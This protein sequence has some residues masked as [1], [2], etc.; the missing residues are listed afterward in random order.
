MKKIRILFIALCF[1][2]GLFAQPMHNMHSA[3]AENPDMAYYAAE[4]LSLYIQ[5]ESVSGNE[6]NAGI[7][8]SELATQMGLHLKIFTCETNS[9][10]FAASLYPLEEGKPNVVFIS[11]VDVV[12]PGE[13]SL[14]TY[15]PFG[16]VIADGFVWGRGAIDCKSLGIMQLIAIAHFV[17]FAVENDLPY[18]FTLLAVSN[19]ELGGKLGARIIAEHFLDELNPVAV[20]GEGGAGIKGI[21][22]ANPD[23][24]YFGIEVEQ[25]TNLWFR[26]MASNAVSGHGSIPP[27][28]YPAKQIAHITSSL[29]GSKQPIKITPSGRQM[30][31]KLAEHEKGFLKFALR[32]MNFC[33]IFFP[34]K[35]RQDP[36]I[37]ALLTNTITVT[38]LESSKTASNQIAHSSVATFDCRLLPGVTPEKFLKANRKHFGDLYH[39]I[40]IIDISPMSTTSEAGY[41]YV[42]LSNAIQNVYEG[43]LTGPMLF[44]AINDNAY[45][46]EKGIPTYGL[47]PFILTQEL[48]ESIHYFDERIE[49]ESLERGT[50]VYK[51]LIRN[52]LYGI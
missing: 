20:Y 33:K 35:I 50:D 40:E 47:N 41:F 42:A 6:I 8:L 29:T 24:T 12:P 14:W 48:I 16:G 31:R 45:F 38:G 13:D 27:N 5:T 19:E 15:P 9:Y 44:P 36:F 1:S 52:I 51:A 11:H 17:G 30:F 37:N 32:N 3:D 49:L 34:G 23:A 26:I 4:I 43:A 21:V 28:I 46:R 18:N 2:S 7:F 25:K 10:N 22:A 39:E